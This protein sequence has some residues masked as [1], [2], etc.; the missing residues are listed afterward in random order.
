M[1]IN[2]RVLSICL[3]VMLVAAMAIPAAAQTIVM[4]R[5]YCG[6]GYG[7]SDTCNSNS[8]H[9]VIEVWDGQTT[10]RT[11]VI[12]YGSGGQYLGTNP[13]SA[14]VDM[15]VTSGSKNDTIGHIECTHYVDGNWASW[16][17]VQAG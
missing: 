15:S 6:I 14:Q 5:E 1:K 4:G 17:S 10:V 3:A 9:C 8:Y 11:G 2:K 7:T 13:G 12:I 16:E